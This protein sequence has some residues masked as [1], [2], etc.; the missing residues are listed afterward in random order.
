MVFNP[1]KAFK[2]KEKD[3]VIDLSDMHRVSSKTQTQ[4]SQESEENLGF[5]GNL[6]SASETT[7]KGVRSNSIDPERLE[8]FGRRIDRVLERI[9][10]LERKIERVEHRLDIGS[11]SR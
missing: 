6:A 4:A 1:L 2:K 9:E 8:R 5:L 7:G 3:V 10:L 11:S